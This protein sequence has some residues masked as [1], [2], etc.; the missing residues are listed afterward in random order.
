MAAVTHIDSSAVEALKEL[1]QE[2][3]ARDIQL[4]ISNPNKDV[5]MTIARSGMVELVG[6]EWYFVRVHDAV[7]VCLTYVQSSNS[8]EQKEPSF[9]RRFGNNGSSNNSSYS[10]IQP[11][12]TLLKEALLSGEK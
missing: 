2:Y 10:D 11:G 6:K 8:E 4:A 12:N 5:H 3:K 7:Q 1:Y 9:L